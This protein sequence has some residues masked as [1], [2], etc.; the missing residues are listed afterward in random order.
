[1]LGA[2]NRPLAVFFARKPAVGNVF[3]QQLS[4]YRFERSLTI[5]HT[6]HQVSRTA[7]SSA[8]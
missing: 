8:K 5:E 4:I 7:F 1:M 2:E 6:G 3:E